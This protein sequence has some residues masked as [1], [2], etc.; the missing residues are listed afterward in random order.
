MSHFY[1]DHRARFW[2]VPCNR[3][4]QKPQTLPRRASPFRAFYAGTSAKMFEC[5]TKGAILLV[6]KARLRTSDALLAASRLR[7]LES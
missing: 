3:D 5:A 4:G 1:S 7:R 2:R 6:A